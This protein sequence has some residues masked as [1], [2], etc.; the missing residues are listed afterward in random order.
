MSFEEKG[1]WGYMTVLLVVSG[2]YFAVVLG[3]VGDMPV[4]EIAYIVP[5]VS[6]I[7]V[8]IF[9]TIAAYILAAISAPSEAD[10]KDERDKSIHRYGE[11]VGF[12]VLSLM[13][14]VPLGLA[15]AEF[16]QFWIANAIFLAGVIAGIVSSTFKIVAYRRG[17]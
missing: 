10:K 4:S 11:S 9:A 8:T 15:M 3:Q 1:T 2:L 13:I 16:E 6:A 5:M 17:V 14:L 12:S 7:V